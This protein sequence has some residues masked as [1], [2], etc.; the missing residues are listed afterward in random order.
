MSRED[1][2][3]LDFVVYR[4]LYDSS[5]EFGKRDAGVV[6]SWIVQH[7]V[8]FDLDEGHGFLLDGDYGES[9]Y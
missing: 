8:N 7:V 2:G 5:F 1:F 3:S 9:E 6:W 4:V